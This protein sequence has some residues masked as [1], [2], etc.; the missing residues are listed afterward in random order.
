MPDVDT[1]SHYKSFMMI[2]DHFPSGSYQALKTKSREA[3]SKTNHS[4][5]AAKPSTAIR[6]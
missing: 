4:F 1:Q 3:S 2:P 5:E 6:G